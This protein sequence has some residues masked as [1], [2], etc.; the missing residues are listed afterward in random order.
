M[1]WPVVLACLAVLG[2]ERSTVG[3]DQLAQPGWQPQHA[4]FEGNQLYAVALADKNVGWIVGGEGAILHSE[5]VGANWSYQSS[6]TVH[7]LRGVAAFDGDTAWVVGQKGSVLRTITGGRVWLPCFVGVPDHNYNAVAY[8]DAHHVWV[9][10]DTGTI[11][12][13]SDG[14]RSWR[15]VSG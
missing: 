3:T 5:D 4:T 9:V 10:G 14:G 2:C 12:T 8:V 1:R 13:T 15:Q 6:G 7:D 11:I